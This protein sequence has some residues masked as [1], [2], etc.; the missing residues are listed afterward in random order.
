MRGIFTSALLFVV[1]FAAISARGDLTLAEL[2]QN[3]NGKVSL[4]S[5]LQAWRV[6]QLFEFLAHRTR[7]RATFG[8]DRA[9]QLALDMSL[10]LGFDDVPCRYLLS[11]AVHLTGLQPSLTSDGLHFACTNSVDD[12]LKF[13]SCWQ[14]DGDAVHEDLHRRLEKEVELVALSPW[15]VRQLIEFLA[16]VSINK[17]YIIDPGITSCVG[18][19][20]GVVSKGKTAREMLDNMCR[21]NGLAYK[22]QGRVLFLT[23]DKSKA[24]DL[25]RE[26]GSS[27]ISVM[28]C[29][30]QWSL[31]RVMDIMSRSFNE[32]VHISPF[33]IRR[34]ASY[35]DLKLMFYFRELP[36]KH[37]FAWMIHLSDLRG[38]VRDDVVYIST[39]K[40]LKVNDPVFQC[41]AAT[42]DAETARV[43]RA[44]DTKVTMSVGWGQLRDVLCAMARASDAS[45]LVAPQALERMDARSKVTIQAGSYSCREILDKL[46]RERGVVYTVQGGMIFIEP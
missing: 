22:I 17:S 19:H 44:L 33:V 34:G 43:R 20:R 5:G 42:D 23:V 25:R 13:V 26:L 7:I 4:Q 39:A 9:S 46:T 37:A 41:W 30:R 16:H 45:I 2:D 27:R 24:M 3:L 32:R 29:D 21:D 35:T 11:W 6:R 31:P 12:R 14:E 38:E 28:C 1:L 8:Q 18:W 36:A 15:R 10:F 40:E